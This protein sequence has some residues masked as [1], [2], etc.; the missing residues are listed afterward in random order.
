M[1]GGLRFN[2][3]VI[4]TQESLVRL[5]PALGAGLAAVDLSPEDMPQIWGL[6]EAAPLW[7][8]VIRIVGPAHLVVSQD[9]E[10]L[11]LIRGSEAQLVKSGPYSLMTL[12]AGVL[13]RTDSAPS[14]DRFAKAEHLLKIL[15]SV[16][17]HGQ[18]GTVLVVPAGPA[19]WREAL[20]FRHALDERSATFSRS[21]LDDV[22]EP[23]TEGTEAA[24]TTGPPP[25][26]RLSRSHS[27]LA[28]LSQRLLI[29]I[30]QLTAA[31]GAVVLGGDLSLIGFGAT[32]TL[33]GEDFAL[34][35]VDAVTG[36]VSHGK[37]VASLVGGDQAGA[38]R[39]VRRF[40]DCLGFV[41]TPE[42]GV[43]LFVWGGPDQRLLAL[44]GL[45]D[46]LTEY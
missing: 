32:I 45:Q 31:G 26:P 28:D 11:G 34:S 6:L 8:P 13:D 41:G 42:G 24:A 20:D 39:F 23:S 37:P 35:V 9:H 16:Q 15:A 19:A 43:N 4:L 14:P 12:V 21:R 3:P 27:L 18:G 25:S 7:Q 22:E 38:A 5:A 40:P 33:P 29:Q 36:L 17:R 46:L 30:G 2:E 1:P 44:V 10:V